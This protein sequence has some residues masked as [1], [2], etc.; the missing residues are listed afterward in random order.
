MCKQQCRH[1]WIVLGLVITALPLAACREARASS[2]GEPQ[3]KAKSA[4]V[5]P[6][7]RTELSRVTL[8]ARAAQRLDIKTDTVRESPVAR[9]GN[10]Q[11]RK[12]IPYAAVLYDAN[13]AS[14]VY[15][16]PEPLVYVRQ[17]ITIDYIEGGVA[18]LVD[19]PASGVKVVTVGA[20]LLFGTEFEVGEG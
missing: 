19:G 2:E 5:E 11:L 8:T 3:E 16:N 20:S 12:V 7:E 4:N 13:G 9:L 17:R 10:S 6:I 1:M 14:W 18:V 15:T